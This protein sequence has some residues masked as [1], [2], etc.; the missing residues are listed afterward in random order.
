MT[1][2]IQ[3]AV[4]LID[5]DKAKAKKAKQK[6]P[7]YSKETKELIVELVKADPTTKK[8]LAKHI[9]L[10][11]IDY[12]AKPVSPKKLRAPKAKKMNVTAKPKDMSVAKIIADLQAERDKINQQIALLNQLSKTGFELTK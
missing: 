1:I 6:R 12:W 7:T 10:N 5:A 4:N 2:T 11:T 9:N 3:D 8:E